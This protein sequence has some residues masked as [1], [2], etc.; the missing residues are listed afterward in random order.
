MEP[1]ENSEEWFERM[2]GFKENL[3]SVNENF[4][5]HEEGGFV[6]L[7]SKVNLAKYCA[8]HFEIRKLSS[9]Q[10]LTPRGGGKLHLIRGNGTKSNPLNLVDV[11]AAEANP[12][13][14]G[15]TFQVA[16]NFNCLDHVPQGNHRPPQGTC[17][18]YYTRLVQGPPADVAC[19]PAL[20]Y[21]QYFLPLPNGTIGQVDINNDLNLLSETPIPVHDGYTYIPESLAKDPQFIQFDWENLDHYP[22]GL[23]T[24][25]D[26]T[27]DRA[28]HGMFKLVPP[29]QRVHQVFC[30]AVAFNNYGS[31]DP[32]VYR[33][34]S[35]ILRAEYRATILAAWENSLNFPGRPGSNKCFL[36]LIGGGVFLTPMQIVT[37]AIN[38]CKDIIV[39]SGLDV[40]IVCFDEKVYT[41]VHAYCG[42]TVE[43]TGGSIIRG[44]L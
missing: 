26:V 21:R 4:E 5:V 17:S 44:N 10:R 2:F 8:G 41:N 37:D 16:S 31:K 38:E 39:A 22:I 36:T 15:A 27:M 12:D 19:G 28:P 6:F 18:E 20:L 29:P 14:H 43:E 7:R 9:F 40:Y 11:I 42:K 35:Y 24:E 32:F 3:Q 1:F 23:H 13:N 34:A 33:I 25:V 30:S